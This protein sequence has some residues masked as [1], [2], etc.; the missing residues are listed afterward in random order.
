MLGLTFK[1]AAHPRQILALECTVCHTYMDVEDKSQLIAALFG[2]KVFSIC[3][4]CGTEVDKGIM[5]DSGYRLRWLRRLRKL[6]RISSGLSLE[7]RLKAAEYYQSWKSG[8][9]D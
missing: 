5:M 4:G 2:A 1:L 6:Q 9:L 7:E 8:E 3:S